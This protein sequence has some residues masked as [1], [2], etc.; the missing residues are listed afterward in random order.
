[1]KE[2]F[3]GMRG[4]SESP[5]VRELN[6]KLFGNTSDLYT[7]VSVCGIQP[8]TRRNSEI[9]LLMIFDYYDDSGERVRRA[10][11]E[12]ERGIRITCGKG[13]SRCIDV[14]PGTK[15]YLRSIALSIEIKGHSGNNVLIE[16][17]DIFVKYDGKW[18]PVNSKFIDQAMTCKRFIAASTRQELFNVNSFVYFPNILKTDLRSKLTDHGLKRQ[19]ICADTSLD[20]VIEMCIYQESLHGFEGRNWYSLG[21]HKFN[22]EL[23]R[24][25]LNHYYA[26]MHPGCLEQEKLEI[27]GK[28]YIDN[29]NKEWSKRL[30]EEMIMFCGVA[31]TGK[32][33][34]LLRT[35]NQL[36][37][38]YNDPVLFL[39]FNR[40]LARDLE[41]LMQLQ[42]LGG[43]ARMA[44][45]T[46]D[47]FMF[48]IAY[49]L[50]LYESWEG[51]I[52][53]NTREDGIDE[54]YD[55]VRSLVLESLDDKNNVIKCRKDLREFSYVAIDEGQDW[56]SDERDIIFKL[57]SPNNVLIAAGSDQC[58]RAD[59][60]AN[61][62]RDAL[63]LGVKS[64]PV[65][66]KKSLRQTACLN[67]FN[68]KLAYS[69][70]LDWRLDSNDQLLGG[71][72]VLFDNYDKE[73][74]A[75]HFLSELFGEKKFY[76]PIDYMVMAPP[77][78]SA[79]V[80]KTIN[81][82][83]NNIWDGISNKDRDSVPSQDQIRCVSTHS[84]RG[85][86][87]WATMLIDL[88]QWLWFAMNKRRSEIE[89]KPA[90]TFFENQFINDDADSED[91]R[92]LPEWFLIPFTRAKSR[93]YIQLPKTKSL[94]SLLL[95]IQNDCSE[96]VS[97]L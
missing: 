33:L 44:V 48:R 84:C 58:L 28:K 72:I 85:L 16:G 15:Y 54:T 49:K 29:Q 55:V 14:R 2:A 5:L 83:G 1:M 36:L 34:K 10:A 46:I 90:P 67:K 87:G 41:R 91:L 52:A 92:F 79:E 95:D 20:E 56:F 4:K 70:E 61:W 96:F 11:S 21:N 13:V 32:T 47:Q 77:S 75:K 8:G 53:E 59:R 89:K 69:L 19:V 3:Y 81:L 65:P 73:D 64:Y 17:G 68:N 23:A 42:R 24:A 57:F 94:R 25:R 86:E 30:G 40:A 12:I 31:G 74:L 7:A 50:S 43:G 80:L 35:S 38:D 93:M 45:W 18:S 63:D 60:V 76:Y 9:D 26:G 66:G 78:E 37:K 82:L 22:F 6:K 51:F 97:F 39:T 71:E 27:I 88:D 62:K